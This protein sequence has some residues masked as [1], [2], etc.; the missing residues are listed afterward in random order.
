MQIAREWRERARYPATDN[1]EAH[2]PSVSRG[3][4][5]KHEKGVVSV[6]RQAQHRTASRPSPKRARS[7]C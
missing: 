6:S 2:A 1:G 7:P 5:Q 3:L 4:I